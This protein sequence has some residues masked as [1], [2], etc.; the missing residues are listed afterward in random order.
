[1][2]ADADRPETDESTIG[3]IAGKALAT[4]PKPLLGV[5]GTLFQGHRELSQGRGR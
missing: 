2:S 5:R 4:V 1:M 3:A